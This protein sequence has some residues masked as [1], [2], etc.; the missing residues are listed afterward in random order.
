MMFLADG[1]RPGHPGGVGIRDQSSTKTPEDH[2]VAWGGSE[3]LA[4]QARH[5]GGLLK[6][7]SNRAAGALR[8][9]VVV[10]G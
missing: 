2:Q 3:E 5:G 4:A 10:R 7:R 1:F 8:H 9:K 6:S